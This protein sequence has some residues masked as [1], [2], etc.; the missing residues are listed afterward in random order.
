MY[1]CRMEIY[2]VSKECNVLGAFQSL[3]AACMTVGIGY[4]RALRLRKS[5]TIRGRRGA[6]ITAV[7]LTRNKARG[8]KFQ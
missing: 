6:T 7:E 1:I 2:V 4:A 3:N 8:R 5:G